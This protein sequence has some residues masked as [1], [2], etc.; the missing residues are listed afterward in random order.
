MRFPAIW[1]AVFCGALLFAVAAFSAQSAP[2]TGADDQ[3][4]SMD[5]D[6]HHG[7]YGDPHH[8]MYGDPHHG[9]YGDPHHGMYGE[10]RGDASWDNDQFFVS[11]YKEPMFKDRGPAFRQGFRAGYEDGRRDI[12][13]GDES[14]P[15][16]RFRYPDHYRV[17]FGSRDDYIRDYQEGYKTG[18]RRGYAAQV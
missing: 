10:G 7:M 17:E 4:P 11:I 8:G 2:Q 3:Q 16:Y 5:L 1:I 15:G 9:M 14:H 13:D 18:Y 12:E 6:P